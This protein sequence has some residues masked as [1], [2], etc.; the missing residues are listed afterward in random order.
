MREFIRLYLCPQRVRDFDRYTLVQ[1]VLCLL[2]VSGLC[3]AVVFSERMG[4]AGNLVLLILSAV[5]GV[6]SAVFA[7]LQE[8][9][10]FRLCDEQHAD[11]FATAPQEERERS[12]RYYSHLLAL[13]SGR[14]KVLGG[15]RTGAAYLAMIAGV[16]FSLLHQYSVIGSE[17]YLY[18][19]LGDAAVVLL[20]FVL[21]VADSMRA[22]IAYSAFRTDM[23]QEIAFYRARAVAGG[24]R[25]A[26][27]SARQPYEYFLTQQ[28]REEYRSVQRRSGLSV[29]G[30]MAAFV[31]V[32]LTALEDLSSAAQLAVG[33]V[34]V[35]LVALMVFE[36][37]RLQMRMNAILRAN[38]QQLPAT[39][40]GET[41]RG[42]QAAFVRL[43]RTGNLLFGTAIALSVLLAVAVTVTGC[44]LGEI[45]PADILENIAGTL[46]LCLL[47]AGVIVLIVWF[48]VY[49]NYRS[50]VKPIERGFAPNDRRKRD[51]NGGRY[52]GGGK[53]E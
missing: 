31:I 35:L 3:L 38:A 7:A 47:I 26:K 41:M 16:V 22:E 2:T 50:H 46:F 23:R 17:T 15:M 34:A 29:I 24:V 19:L 1:S 10:S 40:E 45:A 9:R 30:W 6:L 20:G 48:A 8:R 36:T 32:F 51:Q 27:E 25:V 52:E 18:C 44:V 14:S 5:A 21:H 43:Q 39:P 13:R 28:L 4:E 33:A 11:D 49:A 53:N 37:V 12:E 42:L